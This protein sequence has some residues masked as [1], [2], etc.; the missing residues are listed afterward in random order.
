[1]RCWLCIIRALWYSATETGSPRVQVWALFCGF[2]VQ[3]QRSELG[4]KNDVC[5]CV[6]V[7][8][9]SKLFELGGYIRIHCSVIYMYRGQLSGSCYKARIRAHNGMGWSAW[10]TES[11]F[12]T[13]GNAP[14]MDTLQSH[15]KIKD[16][17]A[18][19]AERR[20]AKEMEEK[21]KKRK[22]QRL[23]KEKEKRMQQIEIETL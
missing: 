3:V 10:S 8:Q 4:M 7:W 17:V 6:C 16:N 22:K 11:S 20:K 12:K 9:H 23:R 1:M 18:I 5:V 15:P 19:M 2:G 14:S 21:Q 13:T